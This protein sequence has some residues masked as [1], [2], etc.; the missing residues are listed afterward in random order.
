MLSRVKNR[1][2][3]CAG[4]CTIEGNTGTI[5]ASTV[6]LL[7]ILSLLVVPTRVK[8][9]NR[10]YSGHP[11]L[12]NRRYTGTTTVYTLGHKSTLGTDLVMLLIHG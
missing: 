10:H 11:A 7:C 3:Y 9:F 2:L 5:A 6:L 1:S 12:F 8:R 4:V